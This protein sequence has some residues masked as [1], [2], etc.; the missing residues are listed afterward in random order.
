LVR[1]LVP[2]VYM[3]GSANLETPPVTLGYLVPRITD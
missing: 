2:T 3:V 1:V